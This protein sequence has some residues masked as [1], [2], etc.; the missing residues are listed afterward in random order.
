MTVK[1]IKFSHSFLVMRIL[2][3]VNVNHLIKV[4]NESKSEYVLEDGKG[5]DYEG[6]SIAMLL[7]A[8]GECPEAEKEIYQLISQLTGESV[9][10]IK[11]WNITKISE[12]VK[13]FLEANPIETLG[14]F[15]TSV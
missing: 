9:K 6:Y 1:E 14:A 12:F 2:K 11:D 10:A 3:K 5:Y 13:A 4:M 7:T 15:Y 8:L